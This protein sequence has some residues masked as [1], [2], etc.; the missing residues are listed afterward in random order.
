MREAGLAQAQPRPQHD[1]QRPAVR[2]VQA[3]KVHDQQRGP[4]LCQYRTT[5]V[6]CS[7]YGIS[8]ICLIC[9]ALKAHPAP[10]AATTRSEEMMLRHRAP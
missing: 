2:V 10:A 8:V 9:R 6:E 1:A 4:F 5:G 7:E 3:G